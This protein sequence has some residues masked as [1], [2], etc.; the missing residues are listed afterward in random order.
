M[1]R[2]H[3]TGRSLYSVRGSAGSA[4]RPVRLDFFKNVWVT[5]FTPVI[6]RPL[7]S[8]FVLRV[9][10]SRWLE[11]EVPESVG[12]VAQTWRVSVTSCRGETDTSILEGAYAHVR[13]ELEI[14]ETLIQWR[15]DIPVVPNPAPWSYHLPAET[16]PACVYFIRNGTRVKIGTTT[17]LRNRV[18]RFALRAENVALIVP[19]DRETE[20]AFHRR[21]AKYRVG[22][23]EWFEDTGTLY[24]FIETARMEQRV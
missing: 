15:R 5:K 3:T 21:F 24:D 11:I 9:C 1:A 2:Y 17:N 4:R 19:G 18:A 10:R 12:H 14:M 23:T 13:A 7:L 6:H 16:H 20:G 8:Q 22:T